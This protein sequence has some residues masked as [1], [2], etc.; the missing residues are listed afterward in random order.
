MFLPGTSHRYVPRKRPAIHV[1]FDTLLHV[2]VYPST[3]TPPVSPAQG[4]THEP[5]PTRSIT[6]LGILARITVLF[7]R[8]PEYQYLRAPV[9]SAFST[10]GT[11]EDSVLSAFGTL[12]TREDSVVFSFSRPADSREPSHASF[13]YP[14]DSVLQSDSD[15]RVND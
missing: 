15:S 9:L 8:S 11:R 13:W 6:Y 7:Q 2:Y 14:R 5:I 12:G 10:L 1:R 3:C 4:P